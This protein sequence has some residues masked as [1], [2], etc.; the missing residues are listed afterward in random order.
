MLDVTPRRPHSPPDSS[1]KWPEQIA[2]WVR[3]PVDQDI[4]FEVWTADGYGVRELAAA[5]SGDH[6]TRGTEITIVDIG[7]HIGAFAV[8]AATLWPACRLIRVRMRLG[9]R[10]ALETEPAG[11]GRKRGQT[12]GRQNAQGS[13][14]VF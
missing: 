14:P 7:A 4:L 2:F 1:Q 8:L 5:W 11:A 9:Q 13:D 6:A 10:R 12:L 3:G